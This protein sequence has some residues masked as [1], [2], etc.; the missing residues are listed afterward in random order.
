M[1]CNCICLDAFWAVCSV[2]CFAVC[3]GKALQKTKECGFKLR[4]VDA[5]EDIKKITPELL[6][7]TKQDLRVSEQAEKIKVQGAVA[8]V[9][10]FVK[11]KNIH[12]CPR[13]ALEG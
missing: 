10:G 3:F 6:W 7:Q 1:G 13:L 9:Y 8:F 2:T 4:F 11:I 12:A 5:A